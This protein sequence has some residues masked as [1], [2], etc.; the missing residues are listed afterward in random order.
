MR[1]GRATGIVES[2]ASER[3]IMMDPFGKEAP[4]IDLAVL[5]GWILFEDEHLLVF[6]K[7]GW[8]VCHPSKNGPLS[9]LVGAAREYCGVETLHLVSRL[10]RETSGLVILAK[11]RGMASR[12]QRAFQDRL[13]SKRYLAILEGLL[14]EPVR[15]NQSLGRDAESAVYVKQVVKRSR[16][17]QRAVTEFAPLEQRN[18][19][20]LCEVK[21]LTGRKHQIRAHAL[22]LGKPICGDKI[23]GPDESLYLDFIEHGWTPRHEELLHGLKRQALHCAELSFSG[24]EMPGPFHCPLPDDLSAF[25]GG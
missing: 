19:R 9:S 8:V 11:H 15:V 22:W 5:P 4:L 12:L 18:G 14:D 21:L 10:D 23:Y 1:A 3:S 13:V 2:W 20:T 25:F 17:A 24:E 16:S 7:P 6:N